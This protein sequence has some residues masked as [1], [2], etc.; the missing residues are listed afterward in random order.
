[1]TEKLFWDDPY[2]IEF[3]ANVVSQFP[4][5]EGYGVVLD[6]TCFYATSG[7]Q[8]HDLGTLNSVPVQ[9]VRFEDT[10]LVH[11]VAQEIEEQAVVEGRIDWARRFDH[12]QQHS[13]QHIL[14]AAF[15]RLYG[16]ETSSFHLGEEY[17][18]IELSRRDLSETQIQEAL[19]T[20]ND[21]L[22]AAAPLQTFFLNPDECDQYPLRKKS[23]L[24]ESL[25][26]V[27]IGDFDLS[28]CSGTHV[29]NAAEIGLIFIYGFEKL[30]QTLKVTFL[31][32]NR[33]PK[34]YAMDLAVLKT[35]S[36]HLTTSFELLPD[37]VSK[38]QSQLKETRKQA[39]RYK[40]DSLRLEAAKL[41]QDAVRG[42]G[43]SLVI[44]AWKRPYDEVRFLAQRL[45]ELPEHCG[46]LLSVSEN[47]VVFF[48]HP[49][50]A[51]D[52]RPSFQQLLQTSGAK[53]GGP[54]HFLEAGNIRLFDDPEQLLLSFFKS[55]QNT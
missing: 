6:R 17:C 11:V 9:D 4:V 43:C 51:L 26:I 25:R 52:L 7:G 12:M 40:E 16:A 8:P 20:A 1:M 23:D 48:K 38:L 5:Q 22:F 42:Q 3:T 47:R 50:L 13:G 49:Q 44:A 35:L 19:K 21:V 29:R 28:P 54:P 14:S 2:K 36:K 55:T 27:K 10:A 45:S 33:I 41:A 18:S 39:S 15:F 37:S 32:G 30:S 53:G 46:A 34:Q 31:C 24:A